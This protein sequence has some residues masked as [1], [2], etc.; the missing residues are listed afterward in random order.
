MR[1]LESIQ[2][3]DGGKEMKCRELQFGDWCCNEHGFPMHIT[4]VGED[5][6]Y[7]TW[8]DNEGDPWEFDDKDDQPQPIVLTPE[9]LEK[10]RWHFNLTPYE[11]ELNECCGMSI[12]KH[13]CYADTNID[14]SLFF[15]IM[16]EEMGRLDVNNHHLKRY[17][18]FV[19]RDTLY[20]HELQRALRLCGLNE[21]ADNFKV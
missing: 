9:I 12:D 2:K 15:P 20:V 1:H 14:I 18:E 8:E 7:A 19:L 16:G 13:W 3:N 6:A 11:K 21:L 5:Y 17:L 10:N 4:N